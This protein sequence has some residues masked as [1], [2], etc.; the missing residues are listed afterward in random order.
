MWLLWLA[1]ALLAALAEVA[2]LNFVLLMFAGGALAAALADG[3]GAPLAV[4]VVVFAAV[5]TLLL[6]GA[7]PPL[8][9]WNQRTHREPTNVAALVGR[10]AEVVAEVDPRGGQVKLAGEIWSARAEGATTVLPVGARVHV[11]RIDGAT[12]VVS[13]EPPSVRPPAL[14]A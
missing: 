3:L 4:E 5:S 9:A 14:D 6:V 7:R 10:S 11:V 12:A 13:D 8:V 1:I 2:S